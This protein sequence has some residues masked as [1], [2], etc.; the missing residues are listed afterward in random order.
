MSPKAPRDYW[1]IVTTYLCI[2]LT[3]FFLFM[4]YKITFISMCLQFGDCIFC[5]REHM[6]FAMFGVE[7]RA[8][9]TVG[10]LKTGCVRLYLTAC[11]FSEYAS[12]LVSRALGYWCIFPLSV[13]KD[14]ALS[15]VSSFKAG[16]CMQA[17]TYSRQAFSH[18][19]LSLFNF[20]LFP[21]CDSVLLSCLGWPGICLMTQPH[22]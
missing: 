21:N 5:F 17:L 11:R 6:P 10:I 7:P 16:D 14:H 1:S 20:F 15:A 13:Y 8:S 3:L 12:A 19:I 22:L 4:Y 18:D 2:Y 9:Q